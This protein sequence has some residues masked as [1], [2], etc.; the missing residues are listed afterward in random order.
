MSYRLASVTVLVL[1]L[2]A[3]PALAAAEPRLKL[4]TKKTRAGD[5]VVV[6]VEGVTDEPRG[7]GGKVPLVF[8]PIKKGW[9]AV[10]AVPYDDAPAQLEVAIA[11]TELRQTIEVAPRTWAEEKVDV[12]PDM[13]EPPADKRKIIDADNAAVIE[14][15]KVD[16]A[17]RFKTRFTKPGPG[18]QT[19]Q[20]GAWRTLNGDY[21]SRHLG[22][23]LA[24]RKGAPVRAIQDGR[25]TLVRD[26]FLMGQTVV[27]VHGAGIASTYFHLDGIK[28]AVGN[29]V[30]RGT[31]LGK[32][33]LS[34][35]T[36]GPHIHLGVW[37]PGG[38]VDPAAFLKL[39][40]GPAVVPPAATAAKR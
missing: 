8:Y 37:V 40:L 39:K 5:P 6:T 21:R 11:K 4:S 25:V 33:G 28:V 30:K 19:S 1:G 24:A 32:V 7:T 29:E 27:L 16:G 17:P 31:V 14:A 22:L 20:F 12:A 15:I 34:G 18:R 9:Q 10:F 26:G 38:F 35:R 36:T 23:D 3:L 13:A 2:T